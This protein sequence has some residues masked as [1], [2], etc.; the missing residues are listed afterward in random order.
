[1][2]R[3]FVNALA[4]HTVNV[5]F[6]LSETS[7]G[8]E[9]AG[10]VNPKASRMV[11][12]YEHPAR[13]WTEALPIGNGRLGGMVFG[14]TATERIQQSED[15]IWA[16]EPRDRTDP[17]SPKTLPRVRQLL[18]D[19]KPA[20]AENLA[21]TTMMPFPERMPRYQPLGLL[22]LTF[23][24]HAACSDYIREL[25]LDWGIVRL[26]SRVGGVV[27]RREVLASAPNQVLVVR[28]TSDQP[29]RVSFTAT[30]NRPRVGRTD[31]VAADRVSLRGE[32]I[33]WDVAR[34]LDETK[35]GVQFGSVLR[36]IPDGG[37]IQTAGDYIEVRDA[38]SATLL[39]AAA[40]NFRSRDP[41]T[42]CE[43]GLTP[44]EQ[45][46]VR[47]RARHM[48]DHQ[49]L[50]HLVE[51][52]A[53]GPTEDGSSNHNPKMYSGA[54]PL[55]KRV[56][57]TISEDLR[58][59]AQGRNL[60]DPARSSHEADCRDRLAFETDR[61]QDRVSISG[62]HGRGIQEADRSDSRSVSA[63]HTGAKVIE[64]RW[65]LARSESRLSVDTS[66]LPATCLE[67]SEILVATSGNAPIRIS[68]FELATS[69]RSG[70]VSGSCS[71]EGGLD[72]TRR[73]A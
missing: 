7:R 62:V 67:L 22:Q 40:T 72:E 70:H 63:I 12:R 55:S 32:A 18:F 25:D 60:A 34:H 30:L 56:R 47:L 26:T 71:S 6:C 1:M 42:A 29:G 38:D 27:F 4:L 58:Q 49:A 35:V 16:G 68:R 69:A 46:Y 28:V 11:V 10:V 13:S 17:E 5:T 64:N 31:V 61:V 45:P 37:R 41:V 23:P 59:D 3:A 43:R 48:S 15:T 8:N 66:C 14:G 54:Y 52:E 53:A 2:S 36:I 50:F 44:A 20:E 57:T 24:E 9:P 65:L 21:E 39:I 51:L 19:G 33:A 73:G